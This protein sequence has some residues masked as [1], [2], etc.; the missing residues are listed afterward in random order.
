MAGPDFSSMTDE[1]LRDFIS[2]PAIAAGQ[3]KAKAPS[4]PA[5]PVDNTMGMSGPELF[6]AGMGKRAMQIPR[7]V[8]ELAIGAFGSPEAIAEYNKEK[9]EQKRIDKQLMSNV[10]AQVGAPVLDIATA[11]LLPAKLLPQVI[12]AAGGAAISPTEGSIKGM[13]LPTRVVQGTTAGVPTYGVG[14]TLGLLGKLSG[15]ASGRYT[16]EGVEALR[17]NE[18]ARRLGINRSVSDLD[19]SS[20]LAAFETSLPGYARNVERQVQAF[21]KAAQQTKDIPSATGRSFTERTLPGENLRT[22]IDEAGKN[23]QATG[24]QLWNDL[25]S[26]IVQNNIAPVTAKNTH[27]RGAEVLVK[28]SPKRNGQMIVEKNPIYQRIDEA[29]PDAAQML[30]QMMSDA[31][32]HPKV[33]FSDLHKVQAAVGKALARAE[34]DAAAPGASTID[35]QARRELKNLYGSMMSDVDAWGTKV[36]EAQ[37]LYED[38]RTFWRDA[39]V[40][41]V[42]TN[43]VY[44]KAARGSYGM[45]PRGYAEPSQLYSDVVKNPRAVEELYPYMNQQGQDLT[46]T[47]QTMPDVSRALITNQPHPPAPGMGTLTT[48]AGMLVGSPLQLVKGAMS[49]MPVLQNVAGSEAAKKAY[50]A[51][52]VLEGTPIGQAAWGAAEIPEQK[53]ESGLERLWAGQ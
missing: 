13:E 12:A 39:V 28:Y 47:L 21:N 50:F 29:D 5:A 11:S 4:V 41:G 51:R 49:H 7:G 16:P 20:P 53:I 37:K 46:D 27:I 24:T 17:L 48:T 3:E 25:D 52:D 22:A 10:E 26:Y 34:K 6:M 9:A 30:V 19:P 23:L 33:P 43:K 14:K 15:A 18:A 40:P 32:N 36:P 45:N 1:Q 2:A 31:K 35:R 42:I 8:K 38:A 44:N